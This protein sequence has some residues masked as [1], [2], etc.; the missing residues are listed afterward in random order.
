MVVKLL[1]VDN[2]ASVSEVLQIYLSNQLSDFTIISAA[3]GE[4]ALLTVEKMSA[5][6]DLPDITLMDLKMPVMNGIEATRRL[7]GLGV[8]NI[9]ILT[10]YLDSDL[11]AE[12][13]NAGAKGLLMKSEGYKA[14]A[15]KL[16]NFIR[17]M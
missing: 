16:A 14:I 6:G 10:G 5:E 7:A 9:Y 15:D 13:S 11:V 8:E 17:G 4:E 12:A 2:E 1:V 3:N